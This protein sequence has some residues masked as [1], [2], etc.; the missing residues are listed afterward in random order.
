M[1]GSSVCYREVQ[2][3]IPVEASPFCVDFSAQYFCVA[4]A[5]HTVSLSVPV[6]QLVGSRV[7]EV[8]FVYQR[9]RVRP[10][11]PPFIFFLLAVQ[12][13]LMLCILL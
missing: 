13:F 11:P 7:G 2:G 3:S 12:L 9:F 5:A 10:L 6:E 1:V 4:E 8:Q